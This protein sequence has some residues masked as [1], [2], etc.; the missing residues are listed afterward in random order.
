MKITQKQ[1]D[2][3]EILHEEHKDIP[4]Q[5]KIITAMLNIL[6]IDWHCIAII[7]QTKIGFHIT[8]DSIKE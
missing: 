4:E 2:L 1:A 7:A 3:I 5:S 6:E 8:S